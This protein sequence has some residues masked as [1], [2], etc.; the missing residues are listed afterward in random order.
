[1]SPLVRT[2]AG[3]QEGSQHGV[4][5]GLAV[6]PRHH[7]CLALVA[8]HTLARLSAS[9]DHH[10]TKSKVNSGTRRGA[11]RALE[12]RAE[13]PFRQVLPAGGGGT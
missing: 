3:G 4:A 8:V 6:S 5:V 12:G 2:R 13:A 11:G 1:M 9:L 10:H 7:L